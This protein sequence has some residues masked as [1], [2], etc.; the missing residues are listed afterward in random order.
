MSL[1]NHSSDK[2]SLE[3]EIKQIK[4]DQKKL[5]T[6]KEKLNEKVAK[7]KSENT[8]LLVGEKKSS[9]NLNKKETLL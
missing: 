1:K 2:I 4:V 9:E 8:D 7:L 3:N 5:E 6:E